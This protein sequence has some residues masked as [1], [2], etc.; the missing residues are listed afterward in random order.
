MGAREK[1]PTLPLP[2]APVPRKVAPGAALP[3][4]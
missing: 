1:P 4:V 3:Y 2:H